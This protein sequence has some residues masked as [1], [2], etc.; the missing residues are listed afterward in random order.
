MN[1]QPKD[2]RRGDLAKI[3]I[4]KKQLGLDEQTYRAMLQEVAGVDSAGDLDAQGRS[5]VLAHLRQCGFKA[6][7]KP[8]RRFPGKP[9][10]EKLA[11]TGKLP[12]IKKIEA[13]LAEAKRPWKY[14][15]NTALQ[16]HGHD[17]LEWCNHQELRA[18]IVAFEKD[19]RRHGRYTG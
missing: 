8:G 16:M 4:A 12:M 19:A 18:I 6:L 5:D 13:Y 1:T 14:A 2:A 11:P 15:H 3:H 10:F 9:D 17:R 7:K